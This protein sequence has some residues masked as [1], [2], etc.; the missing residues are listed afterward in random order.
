MTVTVWILTSIRK[1]HRSHM[2][3]S[4]LPPLPSFSLSLSLPVSFPLS[5]PSLLCLSLSPSLS[6]FL[7][8]SFSLSPSL[9]RS[10]AHTR[11]GGFRLSVA[12]CV[13]TRVCVW[14][15]GSVSVRLQTEDGKCLPPPH[16]LYIVSFPSEFAVG[17]CVCVCVCV[18]DC[19]CVCE[20]LC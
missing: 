9:S 19:L 13:C 7:S 14:E 15:I 4:P 2:C 18:C 3:E 5:P 16:I 8:L 10:L 6:L 20:R 1:Q 17:V 11:A 12:E